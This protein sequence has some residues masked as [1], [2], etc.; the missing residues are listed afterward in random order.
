M[1]Q[2][3]ASAWSARNASATSSEVFISPPQPFH[4]PFGLGSQGLGLAARLVARLQ[5]RGVPQ[6]DREVAEPDASVRRRG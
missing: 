3:L 6:A 2:R 4:Q 5:R 1:A